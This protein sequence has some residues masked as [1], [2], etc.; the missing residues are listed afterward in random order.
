M[1]AES[2][3]SSLPPSFGEL[4]D[5]AE[6][7]LAEADQ[8][9]VADFLAEHP[10]AVAA[11]WAWVQDF[12]KKTQPVQLHEMPGGL[13]ERLV[14]LYTER[15][16]VRPLEKLSGWLAGIRRVV[17]EL[18]DPG[19]APGFAAAGLRTQAFEK[20]AQQWVFKTDQCDIWVNSLERPDQRYDLH[21]QVFAAAGDAGGK[22]GSAQLLQEDRE[23]G[24]ATVDAYGEFLLQGVPAGSYDLVVAGEGVEVVCAPVTIGA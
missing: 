13:E 17:A 3:S 12:L 1:N 22:A 11:E 21:G 5:Y 10:Q 24:L 7:R 15:P 19:I 20:G 16:V 9:R 4:L 14:G 6:G 18:A 8:Q 23:V 2:N